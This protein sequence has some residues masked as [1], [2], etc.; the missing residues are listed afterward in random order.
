MRQWVHHPHEQPTCQ[1]RVDERRMMRQLVERRDRRARA[2]AHLVVDGGQLGATVLLSLE[3]VDARRERKRRGAPL[4]AREARAR[5]FASGEAA[6]AAAALSCSSL[7]LA[8]TAASC[9]PSPST[10]PL[11]RALPCRTQVVQQPLHTA[12][13]SPPKCSASAAC[14]QVPVQMT[15]DKDGT[16]RRGCA[17]DA[18]CPRRLASTEMYPRRQ[19]R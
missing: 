18:S 13:G 10:R 19:A 1:H 14:T 8:P 5:R 15:S 11:S 2:E 17:S 12:R 6:S 7:A 4:L 9:A 3:V 16:S